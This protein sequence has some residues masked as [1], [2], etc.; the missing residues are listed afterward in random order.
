M[1]NLDGYRVRVTQTVASTSIFHIQPRSKPQDGGGIN[2][3][4]KEL[5]GYGFK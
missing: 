5:L 3:Q 1:C 4:S 2:N